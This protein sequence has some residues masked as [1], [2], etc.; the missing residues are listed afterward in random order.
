MTFEFYE[1]HFRAKAVK[2]GFSEDDIQ[3]CLAYAQPLIERDLPVIYNTANLC[4]LVGYRKN[5]LKRAALFTS[6]FYRTFKI[7]K[8]SG[9]LREIKEPLPSLKEIQIWILNNILYQIRVSKF[10]KAY[11]PDRNI[12]DNVRFHRNKVKVLSL[13]IKNFFSSIK[14]IDVEKIYR[15]VGYSSNVANLL[16]K[17]CCCDEILP[18]GAPT[19]PY[20]SNIYLIKFDNY[21]AAYCQ[22]KDIRYT[23]YADD[24]IFSGVFD[25]E[26]LI[27]LASHEL[28][29]IGLA[30]NLE[31]TKVMRQNNR[32]M[33]TGVVVNKSLQLPKEQREKIR[34]EVYYIERFGLSDHLKW[35]EN[36]KANYIKHLLGKINYGL[37][38]NPNDKDL[39]EYRS[40]IS[41]FLEI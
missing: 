31:K 25:E 30:M 19:S 15:D 14:R 8:K 9:S 16:S 24:M 4:A 40:F 28:A 41:M 39:K 34:Q 18:Q 2:S 17:L 35:T 6:Y 38:L 1:K 36:N 27:K 5:Y 3:R 23:R 32:Q 26:P 22:Q 13:D 7:K 12:I 10:A 29:K 11:V 37:T 20:L 33:V 21:I